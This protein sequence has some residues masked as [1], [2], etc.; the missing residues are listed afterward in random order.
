MEWCFSASAVL[1]GRNFSRAQPA[2]LWLANLRSCLRHE[3]GAEPPMIGTL[4]KIQNFSL[5]I[6]AVFL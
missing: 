6:D 4:A 2:T 1:S 3:T 5:G